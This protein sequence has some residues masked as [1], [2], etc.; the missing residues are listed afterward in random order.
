MA[1]FKY[2]ARDKF[3]RLVS[4]I[5]VADSGDLAAKKLKEMGYIPISI[6]EAR[7]SKVDKVFKRLK[8]IKLDE[9]N[10][11]TRQLYS[12]QKA[13][14]PLLT[15]LEAISLQVKNQ[16]FK[17]VIQELARDI[18]SGLSFS[19][20]VAK[21]KQVFDDIYV[22]MIKAAETGGTMTEVLQHLTELIEQE[23]DTRSRIKAAI[24]YPIIAFC[25]LCVG[26]LIV[27]TFV[28]P[29]FAAVYSKFDAALPLPTKILITINLAI[30]KYWLLFIVAV[31][32][33]IFGFIRFINSKRGRPIWDNFKLNLY[34]IGPLL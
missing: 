24:R 30:S 15:G 1:N 21:Q 25:V 32:V 27:V 11:F 22:N 6:A 10:V 9:L 12:L 16:Y 17:F 20:A 31:G 34:I 18:K 19:D 5:T 23:M 14:L 4:G 8:G 7:E 13:G 3:S 28:I 2:K 29:R 33:L 26:F